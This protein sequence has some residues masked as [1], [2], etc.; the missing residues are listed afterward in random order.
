M[1]MH[2]N[3]AIVSSYRILNLKYLFLSGVSFL[4][5]CTWSTCG[6]G[7][8]TLAR[9]VKPMF[10][11]NQLGEGGCIIENLISWPLQLCS[12]IYLLMDAPCMKNC[13]KIGPKTGF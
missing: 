6:I 5:D 11:S 7:A 10:L 3:V 2:D 12:Y 8:A 1:I 9:Q 13:Y 4:Q